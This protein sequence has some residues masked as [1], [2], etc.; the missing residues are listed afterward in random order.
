MLPKDILTDLEKGDRT[1]EFLKEEKENL[2]EREVTNSFEWQELA[3]AMANRPWGTGQNQ[4]T[5][6]PYATSNTTRLGQSYLGG[7]AN[8]GGFL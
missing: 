6:V 7:L 5:Y 3:K 2:P 1:M 8:L 4:P